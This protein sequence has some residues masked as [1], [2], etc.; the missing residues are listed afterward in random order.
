MTALADLASRT[1]ALFSIGCRLTCRQPVLIEDNITATHLYRIAQ[2]AVTNAIKHGKPNRIEIGLARTPGRIILAVKDNGSGLPAKPRKKPGMGLRIMRYR[3]G[4]M[5]GSL[6]IQKTTGRGTTVVCSLQ[7][8]A[9]ILV[10]HPEK[11]TEKEY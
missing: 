7:E 5:G 9:S 1:K 2:E 3:A 4:V 10:S 6:A 8:S 11:G